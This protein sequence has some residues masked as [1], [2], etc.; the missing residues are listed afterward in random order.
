MLYLTPLPVSFAVDENDDSDDDAVDDNEDEHDD[1][2]G[3]DDR[4]EDGNH[5]DDSLCAADTIQFKVY[6]YFPLLRS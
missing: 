6:V 2:Y 4:D 1:G 5:Y 3:D